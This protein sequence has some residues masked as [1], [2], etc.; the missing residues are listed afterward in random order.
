MGV[1]WRRGESTGVGLGLSARVAIRATGGMLCR[2]YRRSASIMVCFWTVPSLRIEITIRQINTG[3]IHTRLGS[4]L[5]NVT[6][7]MKRERNKCAVAYKERIALR[8]LARERRCVEQS[9]RA[10]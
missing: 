4:C 10:K 8:E 3:E 2:L 6:A 7:S 5:L 9:K 1:G